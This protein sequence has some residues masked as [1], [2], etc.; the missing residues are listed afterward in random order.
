MNEGIPVVLISAA[1]CRM[2]HP[3]NDAETTRHCLVKLLSLL[4]LLLDITFYIKAHESFIVSQTTQA[5]CHINISTLC[6]G[7]AIIT[8]PTI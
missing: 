5:L 2:L 8:R 4:L 3:A 6:I 7:S 1:M